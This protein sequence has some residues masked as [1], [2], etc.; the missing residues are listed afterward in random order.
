MYSSGVLASALRQLSIFCRWTLALCSLTWLFLPD[1]QAADVSLYGVGK[2]HHYR[3]TAASTIIE[4]ATDPW[5][6]GVS[7]YYAAPGNV[8][9]ASYRPPGGASFLALVNNGSF[10][11]NSAYYSSK[12]L[13]DA[14]RPNGVYA[15]NMTTAHDGTISGAQINLAADAYPAAPRISNYAAA[16]I[17]N[18]AQ[19]FT[20]TWDAFAGGT[21]NDVI[22]VNID[23]APDSS[24]DR[25]FSSP[26]PTQAGSLNGTSTQVLIPANT[27]PASGTWYVKLAF[28]K[29]VNLN[30]TA[31][32]VGGSPVL[33]FG[34]FG[35]ITLCAIT[36]VQA[37][38]GI[39]ITEQPVS[40][41][42]NGCEQAQFS[43]VATG[44]NLSYQWQ[45]NGVDMADEIF[46]TIIIPAATDADELTY[47]VRISS[48]QGSPIYSDAVT[49]TVNMPAAPQIGQHP[50]NQTVDAGQP[51]TFSVVATGTGLT[52]Q[53]RKNGSNINN[54][55]GPSY[56]I[57]NAQEGDEGS[58][59]V[60]VSNCGHNVPSNAALLTVNS[61]PAPLGPGS[62]DPSFA[63][64]NGANNWVN[65]VQPWKR[66]GRLLLG[67]LFST[68][69]SVSRPY[70][71][72]VNPDGSLDTSFNPGVGPNGALVA[73]AVQ[74]DNK[75]LIGGFFTTVG[76]VSRGRLA[77]LLANGSLDTSFVV[78]ASNKVSAI[79]LQ[80]DGRIIVGGEFT[81]F[82]GTPINRIVRLESDGAIDVSFNV[83]TGADAAVQAIVVQPD[84][85]IILGGVF[86]K[87]NNTTRAYIARVNQN[88]T[89]DSA[90][91]PGTGPGGWLNSIA[92]QPDGK[93]VVGG[94]FD[95][96]S[97][98]PRGRVARLNAN[99]T[100]DTT[101]TTGATGANNWVNSV[102]VQPD[103][104]VIIG[105][106]FTAYNGTAAG[107]VARLN[108]NGSLDTSFTT[109]TGFTAAVQ[110][111]LAP[112]DG[113]VVVG[114]TGTVYN[115][116]TV[117]RITR[118]LGLP[119][120]PYPDLDVSVAGANAILRWPVYR[121]GW[122]LRE[123]TS[124]GTAFGTTPN[125]SGTTSSGILTFSVPVAAGNRFFELR[126]SSSP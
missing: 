49:L 64:G 41:T 27:L 60:V 34:E 8:V 76:G 72:A 87:Y 110:W 38:G 54:A 4:D 17:I 92:L 97:G 80:P 36:T 55:T 118:L 31:Y 1:G 61:A 112:G 43:V 35:S 104:K 11:E 46:P 5:E 121:G 51:A 42:V 123:T 37:G 89:L 85:K 90:F 88:G 32:V 77:R 59:S 111:V 30:T 100:L 116:V 98:S 83:G 106:I 122:V 107:Y 115:G 124:L 26:P 120:S 126:H 56:T 82:N 71:A 101:F 52:Y 99:G 103:G 44:S 63:V 25:Y 102:A 113:S 2:H 125:V 6:G 24:G 96:F 13:L 79:A 20:L 81:N 67:G 40:L 47:R 29:I 58:Y 86:S 14:A 7:V 109:G 66:H 108:T 95:N 9:S 84:G 94:I 45:T 91:T 23:S 53:W 15:I 119:D 16:Q 70:V 93:I 22:L 19:N 12:A 57:P 21:A 65:I 69:N 105:G 75:V 114:S 39:Q 33:G 3:Q 48:T 68:Y 73:M 50:G 62:V 117:N 10:F 74:P 18:A 28:L 78:G